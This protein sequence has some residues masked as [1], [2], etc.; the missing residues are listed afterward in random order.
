[1]AIIKFQDNQE[2][3]SDQKEVASFLEKQEVIYEN[4]EIAKLEKSLHEKYD[5]SDEEKQAILD[6][7]A[8]EIKAISERRGYKAA[9]IISL[10]DS[11]PNL[12][13]LLKNFQREHHHTDDE[14]RFIVSGHGVFIIQGNEERFFEVHLDPGDLISVPENTRHYFTLA[15]DRKVVAVRLFVTPEGWVPVYEKEEL[16]A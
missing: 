7:F 1:M 4:W 16:K 15:D 14:V 6:A 10:S 3:L 9:D 13:E 8:T 12:D 5:L 11:N 2:V